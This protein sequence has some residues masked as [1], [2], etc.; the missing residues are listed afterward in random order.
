MLLNL[1][2][3]NGVEYTIIALILAGTL[4]EILSCL[5]LYFMYIFQT[6]KEK[7]EKGEAGKYRKKILKISVPVAITSYFRSGLSTLKQ[8][9][10]PIKLEE[11]G[12]NCQTALSQY[13]VINGMVMPILRFPNVIITTINTLLIPEISELQHRKEKKHIEYVTTRIL[14]MTSIFSVIVIGLFWIFS[15]DLGM[16]IYNNAEVAYYL[17]IL[18]PAIFL[19]YVDDIVDS[20]LKGI[21]KQI[22]VMFAGITDLITSI[23]LIWFLLPVKGSMGYIVVIFASELINFIISIFVLYKNVKFKVNIIEWIINPLISVFVSY[24][25]IYNYSFTF[26][27]GW[28]TLILNCTVFVLIACLTLLA[29]IFIQKQIFKKRIV[30]FHVSK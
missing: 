10:I 25:F 7:V 27:N 30:A 28:V 9:L 6:R 22:S 5:I 16:L 11:S 24:A 18:C 3:P 14:K 21:D 29:L 2:L 26:Q 23:I 12:L 13:G 17:K 4:S 8:I 1:F 19:M 20:I 15:E